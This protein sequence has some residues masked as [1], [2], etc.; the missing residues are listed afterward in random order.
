MRIGMFL[1]HPFPPD[2][3]VANEAH[4][5]L[6]AGHQVVLLC[7]RHDD[8]RPKREVSDGLEIRRY[9]LARSIYRKASALALT[10]PVYF[11]ILRRA[12]E[13]ELGDAELDALHLHD[14]PL[15]GAGLSFG[16]ALGI[17]VVSDLHE[18]YPAAVATYAYANRFPGKWLISP[19]RWRRFEQRHLPR[20]DR[21][22]VVVEEAAQRM[23]G[24][25][26]PS[27]RVHIVSNTVRVDE[28]EGFPRNQE[29]VDDLQRHFSLV[30]IGG[31]DR[32]RG[33]ESVV[34]ALPALRERWSELRL[35]L[36]GDG[37]TRVALQERARALG[38]ADRVRFEGW[39]P[40]SQVP[41]YIAGA[42]VC[43][44]PHLRSEHTDTTIPHKLF[45]YM[46]L[47]RPVLSTD[48]R[49]LARI[50]EE[51]RA[52]VVYRS[53]D[54]R[55]FARALELLKNEAQRREMGTRGRE[56]VLERYNWTRTAAELTRLYEEL[57]EERIEGGSSV[58]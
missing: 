42:S 43:L 21:V 24:L 35:V 20:A 34:E 53:G 3:R 49:P 50:L 28:F 22:I 5:L 1:D 19:D 16:H 57:A 2:P 56:A 25:S 37:A 13:Q 29:L 31:F 55:D 26:I 58:R 46:L 52:G 39:K 15:L 44:I 54:P 33:L 7:L 51:T 30:Y 17:P 10:V 32:H 11:P 14:L 36:V 4:A 45:H 23:H 12:L 9:D 8:S 27:E 48:C 6:Q 47:E 18:N 38:V 41:S 40:L